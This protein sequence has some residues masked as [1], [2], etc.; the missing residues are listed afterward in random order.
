VHGSFHFPYI[1]LDFCLG[2][3]KDTFN[4]YGKKKKKE[5]DVFCLSDDVHVEKETTENKE[6]TTH[7][8]Y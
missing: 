6:S 5:N 1:F 3:R 8:V 4:G 2:K 7:V